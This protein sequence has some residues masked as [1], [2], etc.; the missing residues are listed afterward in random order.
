MLEVYKKGYL[1]TEENLSSRV[2]FVCLF[3]YFNIFK[4]IFYLHQTLLNYNDIPITIDDN[5][6]VT[7]HFLKGV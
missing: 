3:R 5:A 7:R 6:S 2:S 1:N 4:R